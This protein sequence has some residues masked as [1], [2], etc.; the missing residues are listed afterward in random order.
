MA[1][2][3]ASP[4]LVNFIWNKSQSDFQFDES[5]GTQWLQIIQNGLEHSK[6]SIKMRLFAFFNHTEKFL[7]KQLLDSCTLPFEIMSLVGEYFLPHDLFRYQVD[8]RWGEWGECT[9]SVSSHQTLTYQCNLFKMVVTTG[10]SIEVDES[11][12][13]IEPTLT[14]SSKIGHYSSNYSQGYIG[15]NSALLL[16]PGNK[17]ANP[18][19]FLSDG[20]RVCMVNTWKNRE[21]LIQ[22]IQGLPR[23]ELET[24][25]KAISEI[26]TKIKQ[27]Y[28]LVHFQSHSNII[29][30]GCNLL[31][32]ES[33]KDKLR[34]MITI[35]KT[36]ESFVNFR[37]GW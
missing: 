37:L 29:L 10:H 27:S 23:F 4:M 17:W 25:W 34:K 5:Q 36:I 18:E 7:L 15:I 30:F 12:D 28:L 11:G 33:I 6:F 16:Q 1:N 19:L 32:L 9:E 24:K 31:I 22:M 35:Q 2:T 20:Y 13:Q 3:E 21:R 14:I 26:K 8:S